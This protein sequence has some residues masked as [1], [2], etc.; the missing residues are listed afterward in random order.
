MHR[1]SCV[2]AKSPSIHF[3]SFLVQEMAKSIRSKVMRRHRALLRKTVCDPMIQKRQEQ[4]SANLSD[5][6]QQ[7]SGKTI[8][9]LKSVFHPSGSTSNEETMEQQQQE[10]VEEE[11]EVQVQ[12]QQVTEVKQADLTESKKKK[13][14][15]KK[16]LLNAEK[17][18]K[19]LVWFT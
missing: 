15:K 4:L 8:A 11:E 13:N 7:K 17:S 9:N 10:D 1:N 5:S 19:P 3:I 16:V 12:K 2:V 18:R 14:Q 6:L